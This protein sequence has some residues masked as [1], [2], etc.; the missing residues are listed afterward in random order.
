[1]AST[2]TPIYTAPNTNAMNAE[3]MTSP[4]AAMARQRSAEIM[5]SL[6]KGGPKAA[7]EM[8]ATTDPRKGE[9]A[10]LVGEEG[11]EGII[12]KDTEKGGLSGWFKARM[13]G[14]TGKREEGRVVR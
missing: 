13:G 8:M 9:Q 3:T 2:S 12:Q 1:M 14:V 6:K 7:E 4:Q 5:A 10:R 11:L